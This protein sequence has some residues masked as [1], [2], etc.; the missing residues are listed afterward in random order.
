MSTLELERITTSDSSFS[1]SFMRQ[2]LRG[3]SPVQSSSFHVPPTLRSART[4][5]PFGVV[6]G[7]L[8]E[9][10]SPY[11]STFSSFAANSRAL[12]NPTTAAPLSRR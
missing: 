5:A 10:T 4:C 6:P 2:K 1:L 11:S 3:R 7:G 12:K 9:K 8:G